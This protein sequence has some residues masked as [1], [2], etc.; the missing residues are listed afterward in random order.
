ML[1]EVNV[2]DEVNNWENAFTQHFVEG[3]V[4]YSIKDYV[5]P[6]DWYP[7][8]KDSDGNITDQ[9]LIP[10]TVADVVYSTKQDYI[11]AGEPQTDHMFL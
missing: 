5:N 7:V 2:I 10:N 1:S 9:N 8:E 11:D 3:T 4:T 6:V